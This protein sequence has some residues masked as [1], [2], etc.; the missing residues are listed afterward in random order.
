[1][2]GRG[3]THG[4]DVTQAGH[5][6]GQGHFWGQA[7]QPWSTR[8]TLL[9]GQQLFL[10]SGSTAL[11]CALGQSAVELVPGIWLGQGCGAQQRVVQGC[12][13]VPA[14]SHALKQLLVLLVAPAALHLAVQ[15]AQDLVLELQRR[16]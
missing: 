13:N 4:R 15:L 2:R 16:V 1:M 11:R 8:D 6:E 3:I 7:G 10:L 5:C 12:G 14:H 9:P